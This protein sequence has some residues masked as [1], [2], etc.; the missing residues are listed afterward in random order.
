[1]NLLGTGTQRA[2]K[3]SRVQVGSQFLVYASFEASATGADIPTTN[4]ESYNVPDAQTYEEG[5]LGILR[6]DFKFGGLYDFG[7]KPFGNPPGLYPRDDLATV[8]LIN[9]RTEGTQ[10]SYTY[11]RIRSATNSGTVEGG[12]AFN[13][14]DAKNQGR[15]TFP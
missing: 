2:S 6:S 8:N 12:V 7:N 3:L 15:F 1:M 9:S 14:T 13:I 5:I 11:A 4:F 10:W